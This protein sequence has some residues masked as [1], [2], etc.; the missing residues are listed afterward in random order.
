MYHWQNYP[1]AK[2]MAELEKCVV[3]CA[4]CHRLLS[5]GLVELPGKC[6]PFDKITT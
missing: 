3:V 6:F 4:T 2:V 1:W 5:A